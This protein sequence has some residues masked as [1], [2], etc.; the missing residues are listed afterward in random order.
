MSRRAGQ[1]AGGAGTTGGA[2]AG[3]RGVRRRSHTTSGTSTR[4]ASTAN[5]STAPRAVSSTVTEP[6]KAPHPALSPARKPVVVSALASTFS[7]VLSR[8]SIGDRATESL[9]A[10]SWLWVASRSAWRRDSSASSDTTSP[11]LVALL[12]SAR[13]RST[14]AC[15]VL[16]RDSVSTYWPVTS[17]VLVLRECTF[18]SPAS[19]SRV[20]SS[21]E[22][23]TEMVIVLKPPTVFPSGSLEIAS[24]TT[25]PCADAAT[26]RTFAAAA[27]TSLTVIEMSA[28]RASLR[29]NAT[30]GTAVEPSAALTAAAGWSAA[31]PPA[32]LAASRFAEPSALAAGAVAAESEAAPELPAPHPDRATSPIPIARAAAAEES[33]RM[34]RTGMRMVTPLSWM[35]PLRRPAW[36]FGSR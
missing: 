6:V 4:A 15:I 22:V 29:S 26:A 36:R 18:P 31:E 9:R 16:T 11:S 21:S 17:S 27:S 3:V 30:A 25:S 5:G 14:L 23:G 2:A 28:R 20:A 19:R 34:G 13:T 35:L 32:M 12:I 7:S 1:A 33:R 8:T 24:A 10:A